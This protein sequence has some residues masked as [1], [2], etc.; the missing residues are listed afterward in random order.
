MTE[1]WIRTYTGRRF[2]FL[3]PTKDDI[4]IDDMAHALSL[5]N[6]YNGHTPL[7]YSVAQ[8]CL[9][10]A[11][12]AEEMS[13]PSFRLEALLHD[14]PE[15]YT[16][17]VTR[18]LKHALGRAFLD[19]E[20]S[21]T[22][23]VRKWANLPKLPDGY[24]WHSAVHIADNAALQLE[25]KYMLGVDVVKEWGCAPIVCPTMSMS[26]YCREVRPQIVEE[27][28]RALV[29]DELERKGRSLLTSPSFV[30][31]ES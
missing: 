19:I 25:A 12:L 26:W 17:D 15:T 13:G 3:A 29:L 11:D 31:L 20:D 2:P 27:A 14:A 5:I 4:D 21:C 23:A 9:L 24:D 16:G 28:W 7:P 22:R 8:H 10:V 18:P 30:G 6:R 1:P